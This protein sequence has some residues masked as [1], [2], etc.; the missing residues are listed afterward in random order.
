M[1]EREGLMRPLD[2]YVFQIGFELC[3]KPSLLGV[4]WCEFYFLSS[5]RGNDNGS[6]IFRVYECRG[7]RF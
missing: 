7:L 5:I 2:F 6:S 4:V 1:V 3:W